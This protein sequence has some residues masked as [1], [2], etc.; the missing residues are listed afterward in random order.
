MTT[1]PKVP[2]RIPVQ[3]I[4]DKLGV[5]TPTIYRW[6]RSKKAPRLFGSFAITHDWLVKNSGEDF[7]WKK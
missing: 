5:S 1:K 3:T 2:E 6:L 4:A 7:V